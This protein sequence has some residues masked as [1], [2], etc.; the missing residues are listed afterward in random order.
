M[1]N[2]QKF[3][4]KKTRQAAFEE[5]K[6][7]EEYKGED[8]LAWLDMEYHFTP[9]V[10]PCPFCG[11]PA[12]FHTSVMSVCCN[13]DLCGYCSERGATKEDAIKNHN[14]FVKSEEVLRKTRERIRAFRQA[15]E[16]GNDPRYSNPDGE[17][18]MTKEQLVEFLEDLEN[19]AEREVMKGI[20]DEGDGEEYDEDTDRGIDGE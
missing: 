6:K 1:T 9:K 13:D 12:H 20:N 10:L 15:I 14:S 3:R 11:K 4:V 5:F 18:D 8:V 2:G 19:G 17:L 7:S 16:R